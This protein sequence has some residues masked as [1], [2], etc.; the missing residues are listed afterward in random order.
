MKLGRFI[1][2]EG[3]E[4]C[5]KSTQ[6]DTLCAALESSGHTVVR[7]REPGGT[8]LGEKV[9][10]LLQHAPE[11]EGMENRTEL[12]L[13]TASRAQLVEKKIRPALAAGAMVVCD[14]FLDS[15]TVYQGVARQIPADQVAFINSFAVDDCLPDLTIYLDLDPREGLHR[16]MQRTDGVRDRIESERSDFF[17]RVRE[18]YLSLAH[19]QPERIAVIDASGD[20]E[21]VARLVRQ[22]VEAKFHGI[23]E[24][25]G[26]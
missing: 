19:K 25:A 22:T 10:H 16:V 17:E 9:R 1:S 3:S 11:G 26:I 5:G 23:F 12:L 24:R 2:F 18:G 6:I 7:T 13:F 15:T 14:R 4:G 20:V 21:T 8:Q